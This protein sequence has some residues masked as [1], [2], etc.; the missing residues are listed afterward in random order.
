MKKTFVVF[1]AAVFGVLA[2]YAREIPAGEALQNALQ[3]KGTDG[4]MNICRSV[5]AQYRLVRTQQGQ[6]APLYYVFESDKPGFLIASADTR[7]K[8]LLGYTDNGSYADALANLMFKAWLEQFDKSLSAMLAKPETED[9]P[10]P[11]VR[12]A[13]IF[14]SED[15][16]FTFSIPERRNVETSNVPAIPPLLGDIAWNQGTPYNNYCPDFSDG[17]KC[18]TGCVATALAQVMKYH[19]WPQSGIGAVSYESETNGYSLSADFSQST[20]L[21]DNMLSSYISGN[22]TEEQ[23]ASVAK[24]MSDVGISVYMN[25]GQESYALTADMSPAMCNYFK[26]SKKMYVADRCFYTTPGWSELLKAEISARRPVP[27][28][29]QNCKEW[30]GHAFVI[31]GFDA[32]G[33]F[34]VNWGWGGMSNGYFDISLMNPNEAGI[35]G[36]VGAYNGYQQALI[37]MQPD[38]GVTPGRGSAMI[39][40]D[41]GIIF[42]WDESTFQFLACNFGMGEFSGKVG[43]VSTDLQGNVCGQFFEDYE[44]V[45]HYEYLYATCEPEKLNITKEKLGEEYRVVYPAYIDE[46][47]KA[48]MLTSPIVTREGLPVHYN[49]DNISVASFVGDRPEL[50]VNDFKIGAAHYANFPVSFKATLSNSETGEEFNSPLYLYIFDENDNPVTYMYDFYILPPDGSTEINFQ[51]KELLPKGAY[52]AY[53]YFDGFDG[54]NYKIK[55]NNYLEFTIEAEAPEADLNYSNFKFFDSTVYQDETV[56]VSFDVKNNG[57]YTETGYD[58][59]FFRQKKGGWVWIG[60]VSVNKYELEGNGTS[61]SVTL[62]TPI[63]LEPGDYGC[64]IRERLGYDYISYGMNSEYIYPFT[65]KPAQAGIDE[66]KLNNPVDDR[67]PVYDLSGRRVIAPVQGNIYIKNRKKFIAR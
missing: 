24:L 28:V 65:V 57:G 36:T 29:A 52:T 19:K 26:Y 62:N 37:G 42:N 60:W 1:M 43:F 46:N 15:G 7:T 31:D 6:D 11:S 10:L 53:L 56:T 54:Y 5:P 20:Y 39:K 44:D 55:G 9:A 51:L 38:K 45:G 66:L 17:E 50:T 63:S 35:G 25:Y 34:H 13:R 58:L 3:V 64:A 8:P 59:D 22:Y 41:Q 33:L 47:G 61:T 32:S 30:S 12:P 21:W 67:S 23:A 16:S 40:V 14:E 48:Q 49:G 4:R 27:F 2:S 18:V